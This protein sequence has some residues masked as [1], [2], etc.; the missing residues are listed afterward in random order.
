MGLLPL[1]IGA[2]LGYAGAKRNPDGSK[3]GDGGM[4]LPESDVLTNQ[5]M[6]L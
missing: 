5:F 4:G 1:R 6:G 2:E 3:G